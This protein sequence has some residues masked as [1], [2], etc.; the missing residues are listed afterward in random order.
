VRNQSHGIP[1]EALITSDLAE[2]PGRG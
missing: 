1:Q 2:T